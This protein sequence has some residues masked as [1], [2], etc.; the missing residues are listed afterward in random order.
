MKPVETPI[1]YPFLWG[2]LLFFVNQNLIQDVMKKPTVPFRFGLIL[3]FVVLSLSFIH[4]QKTVSGKVI[5]G[6]GQ[7]I[8]SVSVVIKGTTTGTV[9]D[10][11]GA[12]SLSVPNDKAI[13]V[14]S[15]VGFSPRD[16]EVGK[17]TTIDLALTET[18]ELLNAVF[19]TA[20]QKPVRKIETITAVDIIGAKELARAQPINLVDALRFTPGLFVN[21]GPGRT[22]NGVFVRGF[23]DLG[24]NGLIYTSLLFDGLRTFASPE[25]VP[26]AAFRMDMN[27]ERIEVVRGA[28]A[29]LYGRGAAAGA[30]NVISKTGGEKIGGGVRYLNGQNGGNQLDFN[31][32]GP[33]SKNIRYNVGGFYLNDKGLRDNPFP[34]KGFQIRGNVD[35]LLPKGRVRVSGGAINLDV[36]NQI[37]LPYLSGDLSK[38]AP[39]YTTRDVILSKPAFDKFFA[40]DL[41][42]TYPVEG[43]TETFNP[44][45]VMKRG[46]FSQG[47]NIG[48]DFNFDLGN[49]FSL[50]NKG[51]YQDMIIGTQFDFPLTSTYGSSQT[52]V[53]FMSNG[54]GDG[55]SHAKDFINELRLQKTFQNDNVSHSLTGGFYYSTVSNRAVALGQLYSIKTVN[56][57]QRQDSITPFP[58]NAGSLFRNGSYKESVASGFIGD[59]IKFDDNLTINLGAR[60]DK[61]SMD[62]S[63]N[64]YSDASQKAATRKPQHQG[65]SASIGLNYRVNKQSAIYANFLRAYRAPDFSAY[66]TVVYAKY[67]RDSTGRVTGLTRLVGSDAKVLDNNGDTL[68]TTS[69]IP[70]NEIINSLEI[71]YRTSDEN[72]SFDGGIF[73]NTINDR[74]VST[75]IGATA[76]QIPGGDNLIAGVEASMYLA[77]QSFKGIY[78]RASV[79]LQHTR[80]ISLTQSLS[81]TSKVDVSGNKVAGIPSGIYNFSIGY[82]RKGFNVNLNTNTLAGRPVDPF[83]TINYPVATIADINAAYRYKLKEKSSVG[84]KLSIT[85]LLNNQSAMNVV[86]GATDSF[87]RLAKDNNFIASFAHVRGVPQLPRRFWATLEF[88]F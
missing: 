65:M 18:D 9:T 84:L 22:R 74:L 68:Y 29:T 78:G 17:T 48:L 10:V 21:T 39:G 27:V 28:A 31:L 40:K 85:N 79:T 8:P 26:D 66:T 25:L 54:K 16:I 60:F 35:F 59:E 69:S 63:E 41:T 62:L 83:N 37:D 1:I 33:L 76:V 67:L 80:Y 52:R 19:V 32:N 53:L 50:V 20:T 43:S 51:R 72:I 82:E 36:Q 86:S 81:A 45:T 70:R 15:A 44:S 46:N 61:I 42:F 57:A 88:L 4:A 49:G 55:G 12:Y 47:Y 64:R 13:L 2:S 38:P 6:D 30:I 56:A 77:P 5:G 73:L 75:F 71:G 34:D 23:P 11:N 3:S 24:S 14:F 87:Y 7:G 58:L